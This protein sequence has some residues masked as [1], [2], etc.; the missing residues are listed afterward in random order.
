MPGTTRVRFAGADNRKWRAVSSGRR[1]AGNKKFLVTNVLT[2]I[3]IARCIGI[4]G[5]GLRVAV[6][7]CYSMAQIE[8][9]V[10]CYVG[11]TEI[12]HMY[13]AV[14]LSPCLNQKNCVSLT[15]AML[16]LSQHGPLTASLPCACE[17]QADGPNF[18]QRCHVITCAC[19][20]SRCHV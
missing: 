1:L 12:Q 13:T 2:Q 11:L 3:H 14:S 10:C 8:G 20:G 7:P 4:G 9:V 17:C 15:L 6:C 16:A 18:E 5:F 19:C